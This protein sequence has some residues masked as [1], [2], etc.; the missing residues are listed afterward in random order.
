MIDEFNNFVEELNNAE[1]ERCEEWKKKQEESEYR[2][3]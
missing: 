3:K 1:H 2:L